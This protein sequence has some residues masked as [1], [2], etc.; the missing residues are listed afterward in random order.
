[1]P[2][3][4]SPIGQLQDHYDVVVVGSGYGGGI[5]ASR[6]SRAGKRVC[7]LERGR[8]YAP[9]DFPDSPAE[10]AAAMQVSSK[11]GRRGSPTA[12]FDFRNHD[13]IDVLVGCGLGGTS[14]I[15]AGIVVEPDPRVFDDPAWPQ[16]FRDDAE[17][18]VAEG[19]RRARDMLRPTP[20]PDAAPELAKF[21]ALQKAAGFLKAPVRK[22]PIA[23]TFDTPDGG[24]NHVGVPQ[25]GC[26]LCGDCV[27]GCNHTS[28]NTVQMTYL[29]DAWNHGAEIF[30]EVSVRY[31]ARD[32]ERWRVHARALGLGRERF[33]APDIV[34]T[35]D[36]VV[37]AAGAL[38]STEILLR[39]RE[40]GLALSD[41][42]GERF[43]GNGD[44]VAFAYNVDEPVHAVGTGARLPEPGTPVGP[45]ITGMID[46]RDADRPLE[47]GLSIEEG[48]IPGAL[49]PLLPVA[50][51]AAA[52]WGGTDTDPD[53]DDFAEGR[54]ALI[55]LIRGGHYGAAHH[56]QTYLVMGH[57]QNRGSLTLEND[58]LRI[59]W[60]GAGREPVVDLADD[61]LR[62]ATAA[63]GGTYVVN[64]LSKR[65]FGHQ[66]VTVHPLGGCAMAE[67]AEGGVVDHA[68][69]VFAGPHGTS[70]H[71]GLVVADGAIIPRSLGT[72]PLFTICAVAERAIALVA[73]ERGWSYDVALP[74]R[75]QRDAASPTM[76]LRFTE[77]MRGTFLDGAT[78]DERER[79][80]ATPFAFTLTVVLEDLEAT[81]AD[82]ATGFG[83][84]VG[85][86]TAPGLSAEP[87]TVQDGT[88][89]LFV[90]DDD[91]V[92]LR[93]M[94]YRMR[95]GTKE[96]GRYTFEGHKRVRDDAGF[97]LWRDTT[98]LHYTVRQG[99]DDGGAVV[100]GGE[101]R[102]RL[103][104]FARQLTT[105]QVTD[106]PNERARLAAMAR[107]GRLFAGALYDTY[108]GVL[109]PDRRFDADAAPRKR[110]PLLA[111]HP[112]VHP[113]RTDDGVDL[114]LTRYRG[115][116]KGPVLVSHGLGVS[117]R[118][119]S[120]DTVEVNM[121]EYLTAHGYDVWLFDWRGSIDVPASRT[122]F[123]VD[124]VARYDHPAAL[125]TVRAVTGVDTVQVFAHCVGSITFS[126]SVLG[127]WATGV[128]SA[129]LAQVATHL[130]PPA[131]TRFKTGLHVPGVLKALGGKVLDGYTD[132][133]ASWADRLFEAALRLHPMQAEERCTNP[134]CRRITF[135]YGGLFEHDQLDRATHET[136]HEHFGVANLTV[137]E[138]LAL[139]ARRGRL[140]GSRGEDAYLP[141]AERMAFP[142]TLLSGAENDCFLPVSTERTLAYLGE[143]NGIERY[144]RH[145]VPDYGH[146]DCII[147]KNAWKDV[148]PLVLEHLETT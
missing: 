3:L 60:P 105:M 43:T 49:A 14:L 139:M 97:D 75:P 117:S 41:R 36:L 63:L 31:V 38:G 127:G 141:H 128:R 96:G 83:R 26:V 92:G 131:F 82:P 99:D 62:R 116:A 108:G 54:R 24:V 77:T 94:V 132:Q 65:A 119:Y 46:T 143:H 21:R 76:G 7:V 95:L 8:E 140:A 51:A 118:I 71:A 113:V 2:R 4:A 81:L 32:G 53:A 123:S 67:H 134:V 45:C 22:V 5:A 47:E 52:G 13:D 34:V 142:V 87:I 19:Y 28:K 79:A 12:L 111:P 125:A 68:G 86:V 50:L 25:R 29:P 10:A 146:I 122:Q 66:L 100:G 120:L 133:D 57:D 61:R 73:A 6:L 136:L 11:R 72:N 39:S 129:M 23:V 18:G 145:V 56:T 102:I 107:F 35:A 44:I 58:R 147:G 27:S 90:R 78:A 59:D 124:D 98:T 126:A 70:V 48:T 88:F 69:R 64:P 93:R 135:M 30:T 130:V 37:L 148:Y 15:N 40:Q 114:R 1:M 55:G 137:F 84:L 91:E 106:A 104:D 33:G 109:A 74:S 112:E 121:V 16:A 138:Q 89:L 20:Y 103:A 144:R 42:L 85:T 110:R 115:G 80:E 17:G 101:L 9:G